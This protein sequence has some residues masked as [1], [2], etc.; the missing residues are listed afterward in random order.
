MNRKLLRVL[1]VL[2]LASIVLT[3]CGSQPAASEET[4]GEQKVL[5]VWIQWGDNP[6]QIQELFDK[7]TAETGVKVEVT[8]PIEDDKVLPALTGSNPPD[9][10][11]LSGG[12][13]AKS[14]YKEGL[15]DELSSAITTGGIDMTDIYEAPLSQCKQGDKIVCLPW[16]TDAY[17][18][19]WNKDLFEAAGLDPEKPPSTMEE[20]VEYA[21]KLTIIGADGSIEQIGFIHP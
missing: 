11:V 5:R 18:L 20:L 12:D 19:F 3:A 6:Q 13:A 17:A 16:G 7:Y 10:L 2:V 8:A 14:F 9:I 21:E 15:V 1:S 4:G